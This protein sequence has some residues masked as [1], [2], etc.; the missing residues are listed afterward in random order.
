MTTPPT[1]SSRCARKATCRSWVNT[2]ACSPKRESLTARSPPSTPSTARHHQHRAEHLVRDDLARPAARRQHGRQ[3]RRAV[4]RVRRSAPRPPAATASS[5][6]CSTRRADAS[7]ISGPTRWSS[8]AGSPT[9]RASVGRDQARHE[10]VVP[11]TA[12]TST[13]CT[14][15]QDWPGLVGCRTS[16]CARRP[17]RGPADDDQSAQ[18]SAAALPPS[19]SVTCLCGTACGSRAPTGPDP[20][21]DTTGSR[22]SATRAGARSSGT[23]TTDTAPGGRSV[24][25]NSSPSSRA[26][27]RRLGRRLEHD[28]RADGDRGRELVRHQVEREVERR[29]A[30]HRPA[31]EPA[32]QRHAPVG[33]RVGVEPLHL[34]APAPGL[35]GRPAEG[36]DAPGPPR[37]AP[38]SAACPLSAVIS[39]A[40]SS[41]PLGQPG[42][43]VRRAPRPGRAPERRHLAAPAAAAR[44]RRLDLAGVAQAHLGAPAGRRTG[45]GPQELGHGGQ[46]LR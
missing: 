35:L 11:A 40:T 20:V 31:G 6:H 33:C 42:R 23:T 3:V 24:S 39:R 9:T 28:R 13:R 21:N 1:S 29:D 19:S 30:E 34:S 12:S 43:D 16:R 44:D 10:V 38:T 45:C 27:E 46:P 26:D 4:A 36:R 22:G 41:A 37:P 15:T 8:S 32:D 2:P 14:E 5:T 7:L 25:A 17:S 18:T